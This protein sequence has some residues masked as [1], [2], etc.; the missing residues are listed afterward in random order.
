[1]R[2]FLGFP[3]KPPSVSLR[4]ELRGK[5][6]PKKPLRQSLLVVILHKT[7][8]EQDMLISTENLPESE[9]RNIFV[10][11]LIESNA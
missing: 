11:H 5:V 1:M 8:E 2:I 6:R 4:F 10:N 7:A 3:Q 9:K